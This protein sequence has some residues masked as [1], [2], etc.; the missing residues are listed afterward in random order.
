DPHS[1]RAVLGVRHLR[2]QSKH[3]AR[4]K[5][6]SITVH[7]GFQAETFENDIAL[8]RLRSAV[9]YSDYIQPV[10]LPRPPLRPQEMEC[11]ISGWGRTSEA[12]KKSDVLKEARVEII[13]YSI[14]NGS[15]VYSGLISNN[16]ICAGSLSGGIDSCQ[17]DSGGPLACYDPSTQ[18]YYLLGLASFGYGCGRP[19]YPGVYVRVSQYRAW[20]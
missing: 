16:M 12:G 19:N 20:I 9:R 2:E 14:C 8:F 7:P 5:I 4:I 3:A 10:C 18:K 6:R 13:P 15:S 11:F 1:W 17:G